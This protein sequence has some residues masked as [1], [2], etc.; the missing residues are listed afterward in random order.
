VRWDC[1]RFTITRGREPGGFAGWLLRC[2]TSPRPGPLLR[3]RAPG[4]GVP[5]CKN[6][7]AA[8]VAPLHR[9]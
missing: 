3:C 9:R 7:D 2:A 5:L 6:A 4:A 8:G 1:R